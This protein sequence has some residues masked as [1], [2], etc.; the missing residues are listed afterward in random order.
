MAFSPVI[1]E[2]N[3]NPFP[4][5]LTV[6]EEAPEASNWDEAARNAVIEILVTTGDAIWKDKVENHHLAW[7]WGFSGMRNARE[8]L[9]FMIKTAVPVDGEFIILPTKAEM[10]MYW[11]IFGAI[12]YETGYAE[13][14]WPE[15]REETIDKI[16]DI[17][18]RKQR[19]YGHDNIARFGTAGILIRLHDKV[20][21]LENLL[22]KD[23][24]PENESV[25]DNFI[26]LLGYAS[27]GIMWARENYMKEVSQP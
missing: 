10:I 5:K 22:D 2:E 23:A 27:I 20:A 25:V 15:T 19:D 11:S 16:S 26:D 1:D 14:V 17:L 24:G 9:D 7:V 4:I 8:Y 3:T 13:K 6:V 12:C 18:V 21:R